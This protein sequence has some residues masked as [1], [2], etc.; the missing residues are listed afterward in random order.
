MAPTRSTNGEAL[1]Y[2][3]GWYVQEY[4]GRTLVWHSGWWDDAYSALYLKI[5]AQELTFI[6]LANG[7][8]VCW[9]NPLDRAAVQCSEF[10]L[11]TRI[12]G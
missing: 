1:P 7:E 8:G 3:L 4:G 6:L 11:F 9:N 12:C 10:G 5:P 2:G